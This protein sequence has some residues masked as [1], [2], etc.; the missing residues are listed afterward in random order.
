MFFATWKAKILANLETN[1]ISIDPSTSIDPPPPT[2]GAYDHIKGTC[3]SECR[4]CNGVKM[5]QKNDNKIK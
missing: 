4:Y 1:V 5:I 2:K 3:N